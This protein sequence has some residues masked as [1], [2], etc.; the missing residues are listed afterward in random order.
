MTTLV[1]FPVKPETRPYL[2]AARGFAGEP[3]WLTQ[4]R[5]RALARFAEQGF[6]SR[7]GE[8]WRYI[9]L[10]SLQ[11]APL[12]PAVD[13]AGTA[14]CVPRNEIGVAGATY[15]AV[16]G[17]GAGLSGVSVPHGFGEPVHVAA[18]PKLQVTVVVVEFDTVAV[19][20]RGWV[21]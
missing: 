5:R 1:D 20:V 6:P 21:G 18:G 8:A 15:F 9:D 4:L 10:R 19:S 11:E 12:L 13:S 3:D 17:V 2:D 16:A 14:P 7:R